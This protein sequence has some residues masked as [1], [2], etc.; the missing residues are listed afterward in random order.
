MTAFARITEQHDQLALELTPCAGHLYRW[1]LRAVPAGKSQEVILDEFQTW[2]GYS[3]KWVKIAF[4]Q[5]VDYGLVEVVRRYSG[6]IYKLI[7]WHPG[8][9][10]SLNRQES[11]FHQQKTSEKSPAN[12]HS[13]VPSNR[14]FQSKQT[15]EPT[16]HP[17]TEKQDE[18]HTSQPETQYPAYQE[19]LTE[20]EQTGVR[21][22]PHL[23]KVVV[24]AT[25]TAVKDA[26]AALKERMQNGR[27]KNPA[28]FLRQA[29]ENQWQPNSRQNTALGS[30]SSAGNEKQRSAPPG[31]NEWYDLASAIGLVRGATML[32]GVQYVYTNL[33]KQEVWEEFSGMFPMTELK[34]FVKLKNKTIEP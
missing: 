29:I 19:L 32:D 9:Q 15:E 7:A 10:T 25:T 26:I 33:D 16:H 2:A 8:Q 13:S 23:I 31:F 28:G 24:S 22:N 14:E 21:L 1:L 20:A 34:E 4:G 18:S 30:N 3:L 27:V 5:L 17:V 11:S 6:R 12:P